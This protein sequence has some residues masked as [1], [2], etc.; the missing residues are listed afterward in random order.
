MKESE[1]EKWK[2]ENR[3]SAEAATQGYIYLEQTS[4]RQMVEFHVNDYDL[5]HSILA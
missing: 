4:G 1:V 3:I 2:S 5:C